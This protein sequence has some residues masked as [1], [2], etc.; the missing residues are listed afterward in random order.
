MQS[1]HT[2]WVSIRARLWKCSVDQVRYAIEEQ[3]RCISTLKVRRLKVLHALQRLASH[4]YDEALLWC[5]MASVSVRAVFRSGGGL[6]NLAFMREAN[7]VTDCLDYCALA[8]YC[9]GLQIEV[10]F[11]NLP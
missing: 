11:E 2:V 4:C 8:D 7:V 10:L 5:S 1:L 6:R 3:V 9:F